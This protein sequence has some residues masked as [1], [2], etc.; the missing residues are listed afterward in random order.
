MKLEFILIFMTIYAYEF[1]KKIKEKEL[2]VQRIL[3]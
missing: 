3:F 2:Y 1:V